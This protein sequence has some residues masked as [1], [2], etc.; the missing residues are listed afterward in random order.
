MYV[1]LLT[2]SQPDLFR[3]SKE[4]ADDMHMCKPIKSSHFYRSYT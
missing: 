2:K 4:I 1:S 3:N